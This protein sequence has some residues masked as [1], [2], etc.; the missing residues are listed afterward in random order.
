MHFRECET[1]IP[2]LSV[3]TLLAGAQK[4]WFQFLE[5]NKNQ[6]RIHCCSRRRPW[7]FWGNT[8]IIDRPWLCAGPSGGRRSC[9]LLWLSG[10]SLGRVLG[11]RHRK[12]HLEM[13]TLSDLTDQKKLHRLQYKHY[14]PKTI[15][16]NFSSDTVGLVTDFT[17]G[18]REYMKNF[19]TIS[20]RC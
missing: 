12:Y 4:N 19:N 11:N 18:N 10:R 7:H 20:L 3:E 15:S 16:D 9:D 5:N 8:A 1:L 6:K 17:L 2:P 14:S 13:N